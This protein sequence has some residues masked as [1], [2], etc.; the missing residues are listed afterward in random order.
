MNNSQPRFLFLWVV[1]Q[2]HNFPALW[3]AYRRW[4]KRNSIGKNKSFWRKSG[5]KVDILET[6]HDSWPIPCFAPYSTSI[7][8]LVLLLGKRQPDHWT[9]PSNQ[10]HLGEKACC[11]LKGGREEFGVIQSQTHVLFH[12]ILNWSIVKKD[13]VNTKQF[14]FMWILTIHI[15]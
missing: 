6:T 8:P 10:Y 13:S 5:N 7:H 15:N 4:L 11:L 1:S 3:K 12:L 9:S 2:Q 14:C